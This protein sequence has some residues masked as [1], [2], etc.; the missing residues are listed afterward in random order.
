MVPSVNSTDDYSTEKITIRYYMDDLTDFNESILYDDDGKT[1]KSSN[2]EKGTEFLKLN[3]FVDNK[4]D[5]FTFE[6]RNNDLHL[7]F[8]EREINFE[9]I[10]LDSSE[11]EEIQLKENP[12]ITY[13]LKNKIKLNTTQS[14]WY[15]F[16]FETRILIINFNWNVNSRKSI[17]IY[18]TNTKK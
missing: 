18:K 2:D 14:E 16:N 7:D 10:G 9:L 4:T 11:I 8:T 13:Q 15:S 6:S 12:D 5:S 1:F 3:A 17:L